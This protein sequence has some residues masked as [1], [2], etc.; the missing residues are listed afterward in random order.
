[1]KND[2]LYRKPNYCLTDYEW[3]YFI[4][5]NCS[6]IRRKYGGAIAN[7]VHVEQ[8]IYEANIFRDGDVNKPWSLGMFTDS[9]QAQDVINTTLENIHEDTSTVCRVD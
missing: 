6:L 7:I 4:G 1:M 8:G 3:H 2:A 9:K 5:G